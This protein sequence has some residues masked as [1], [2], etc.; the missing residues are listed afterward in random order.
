MNSILSKL[1]GSIERVKIIRLFLLNSEDIFS[2]ASICDRTKVHHASARKEIKL[3]TNIGFIEKKKKV[4][5]KEKI[6]GW[7]LDESFPLLISLRD[8]VLDTTPFSKDKFLK[9]LKK[10]GRIKLVLLSGIFLKKE[11]SR[12]DI[13]VVGDKVKEGSLKRVLKGL[14]AEI[15]KELSYAIFETG[16]F[17]YRVNIYDKFVRDILDY[18]HKEI[19]NKLNI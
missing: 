14:E 9:K 1:F 2:I 16:D 3:L 13:L 8:L 12:V 5:E 10:V 4:I 7:I 15:G 19:I 17:A 6:E 18:P 11:N